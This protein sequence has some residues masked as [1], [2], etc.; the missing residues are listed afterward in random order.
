MRR[1]VFLDR[2]GTVSEE[3]GYINHIDRFRLYPWAAPSIR[4]LNQAGIPVFLV[5]NQAGVARGYFSER[6][7][8]EVHA[9]LERELGD[10]GARLD[11]IYYCPHHPEGV[12][13]FYRVSCECRKPKTG[14]LLRAAREH[15][16]DLSTS[17]V[18]G[19]RY[20][21]LEMGHRVGAR[22]IL[23]LSGYG[24][25]EYTHMRNSWPRP[26]DHVA[27]NLLEAARWILSTLQTQV[28]RG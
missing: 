4:E 2:D 26:P 21:D 12:V 27:S 1:A 20:Y 3:V 18:V 6:L 11:A 13:E 22:G 7:V 10:G 25:G 9:R 14:M 28:G 8:R 19:D 17:F 23:V 16:L 24:Q 15:D 5:T